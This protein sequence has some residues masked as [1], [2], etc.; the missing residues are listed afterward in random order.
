MEDIIF[1][2]LVGMLGANLAK[3]VKDSEVNI[4]NS[5]IAIIIFIVLQFTMI[6]MMLIR[7]TVVYFSSG[8]F[9]YSTIDFEAAFMYPFAF[10]MMVL[11]ILYI[12]NFIERIHS[13]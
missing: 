5:T 8:N 3:K 4:P 2:F 13:R 12:V 10:S 1:Y 11:I 9:I 7:T 6:A